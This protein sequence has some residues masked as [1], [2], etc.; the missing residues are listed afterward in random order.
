MQTDFALA[1]LFDVF[2]L[3]VTYLI[4]TGFTALTS[5]LSQRLLLLSSIHTTGRAPRCGSYRTE[6][7]AQ[8]S[9]HNCSSSVSLVTSAPSPHA[10]PRSGQGP[11]R[12]GNTCWDY[13]ICGERSSVLIER[14]ARLK[15]SSQSISIYFH[16]KNKH[17][18]KDNICFVKARSDWWNAISV[19]SVFTETSVSEFYLS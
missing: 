10:W 11:N 4:V 13:K 3:P 19:L 2:L 9:E 16:R 17:L 15:L 6:Q 5:T 1:T 18:I 8:V 7:A 12:L 14:E